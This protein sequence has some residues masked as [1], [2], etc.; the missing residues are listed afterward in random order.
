MSGLARFFDSFSANES[1]GTMVESE[2]ET[3]VPCAAAGGDRM[4]KAWLFAG[5][6]RGGERAAALYTLL[7]TAR[8]DN[9]DPRASLAD[10]LARIAD[11]RMSDLAALLPWHW[12][13]ER[14]RRN[15]AA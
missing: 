14:E 1:G 15:L 2:R 6:Q 12:A 3:C 7:C 4:R 13:A 5:S 9:V 10:V 11:H 8:L